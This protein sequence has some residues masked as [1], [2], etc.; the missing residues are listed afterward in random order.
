[1]HRT[2]IRYAWIDGRSLND[3]EIPEL[4]DHVVEYLNEEYTRQESGRSTNSSSGT[5]KFRKPSGKIGPGSRHH[6][7]LKYANSLWRMAF[8]FKGINGL[9]EQE[10]IDQTWMFLA[11]QNALVCDPPKS[12]A[13]LEVIFRSSQQFM[14][15]EIEKELEEKLQKKLTEQAEQ[16][17]NLD[18]DSFGAYL[19]KNGIFV[20][21]DPMI[22]LLDKSP[23]R[24]DEWRCNWKI[25]YL[26][27]GDEETME[28]FVDGIDKPIQM[29]VAEFESHTYASRRIQ[30]ETKGRIVLNKTFT[31]WDWKS[32]WDGRKNDS[33]GKEGIT[34]G[35]KEFLRNSSAVRS[36][37]E[38]SLTEQVEDIIGK[39]S[40]PKNSLIEAMDAW[41]NS[42]HKFTGR[43][44]FAPGTTEL[45]TISLPDDPSTGFYAF[46]DEVLL[47]VKFSELTGAYRRSFGGGVSTRHL[48]EAMGEIGYE[49][50]KIFKNKIEGRWYVLKI[51]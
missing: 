20:R 5:A 13:E 6:S 1:M 23:D 43:L 12:E 18:V 42:G 9:E 30:Q 24:I 11:G 19:Q 38:N 27:K 29:T 25:S 46:D 31:Y 37:D 47:L 22:P 28:I 3:I 32:I 2:G 36:R 17:C 8:E 45:T 26:V 41:K 49:R 16:P 50:K 39:L 4:P 14:R 7:L 51:Q 10:V 40:G 33:K 34:R 48:T 44:K 35:L 21:H 15:S